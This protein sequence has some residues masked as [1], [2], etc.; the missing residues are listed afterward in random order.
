M[1]RI[2]SGRPTITDVAALAG[3]SRAAVSK[4]FNGTGS[5]S[6]P[7]AVRIREA[8]RKLNWTPSVAAV[9]LRRSRAQ[10]VGLVLN[11]GEEHLEV[12]VTTEALISGIESVLSQKEYGLLLYEFDYDSDSEASFYRRLADARRVDGVILID[13][14]VGDTRFQ[15]MREIGL[16]AVLLGTP[17]REDPIPHLDADQPG[18]GIPESVQH[19]LDLGHE[20]IAYIGGPDHR[21]PPLVRKLAFQAAMSA[22]GVTPIA[23]IPTDYTPTSSARYT[24]EVLD[25]AEPPS[26]IIY[27]GDMM[28]LAGMHIARKR[29]LRLP[30][31]LSVIGFDGLAIGDWTD[32]ELTTV[33]RD[34]VQR[35]RA[36]AALLLRLLGEELA[37][38]YALVPQELLIRQSTAV[39]PRRP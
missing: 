37:E 9:N 33:R 29:G 26:A 27:G 10:A 14:A 11:R 23:V 8:A 2:G 22:A 1:A 25:L 17:W 19:L 4:V 3:V 15:L 28:A 21:V 5:I 6:E 32:P 38:E 16:P 36:I 39:A 13:S 20:R 7:T 34:P 12:G 35:G 18:S 24:A 30:E 31:D